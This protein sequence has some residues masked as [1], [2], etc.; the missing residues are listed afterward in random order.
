MADNKRDAMVMTIVA[1]E[2]FVMTRFFGVACG[3]FLWKTKT[4][5]DNKSTGSKKK[6]SK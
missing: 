5:D 2:N 1:L 4:D 3:W 6:G